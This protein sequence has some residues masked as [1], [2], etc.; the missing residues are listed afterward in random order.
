MSLR[1]QL[2]V[3]GLRAALQAERRGT[4]CT[5]RDPDAGAFATDPAATLPSGVRVRTA[6]VHGSAEPHRTAAARLLWR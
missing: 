4:A 6:A 2:R 5:G 3:S 1:P